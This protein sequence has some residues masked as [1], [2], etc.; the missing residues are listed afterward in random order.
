M[1]RLIRLA[2]PIA[3]GIYLGITFERWQMRSECDRGEGDW[4]GTICV[5]SE[6]LQ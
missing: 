3:F 4:T 2:I 6:L 1:F 5:G